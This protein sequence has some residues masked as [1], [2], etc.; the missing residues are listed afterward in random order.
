MKNRK[1]HSD[2]A[3]LGMNRQF[4]PTLPEGITERARYQADTL[5]FWRSQAWMAVFFSV[6][7]AGT[8]I[9]LS[10]PHWWT[11]I[12]GA[13][14]AIGVRA[15]YLGSDERKMVW[16]LT[17]DML[18]GPMGRK[19][20]LSNIQKTNVVWTA[21][22]VVTISGDKHMIRYLP[23]PDAVKAELDAARA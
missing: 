17:D 6:L 11:G 3:V 5:T 23:D 9:G 8:L 10:N 7:A 1:H 19:I 14:A 12:V 4:V 22:Q 21:V 18:F 15:F 20:A 16:L 13:M 2:N